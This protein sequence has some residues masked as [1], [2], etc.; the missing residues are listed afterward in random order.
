MQLISIKTIDYSHFL[1][2]VKQ[3]DLPEVAEILFN[4]VD[5]AGIPLFQVQDEDQKTIV[6]QFPTEFLFAILRCLTAFQNVLR[7]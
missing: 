4:I 5:S 1:V 7:S 6:D 2:V 3:D